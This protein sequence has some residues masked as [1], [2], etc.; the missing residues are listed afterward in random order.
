M[1]SQ[2][3]SRSMFIPSAT[4]LGQT[5]RWLACTLAALGSFNGIAALAE[6]AAKP[7]PTAAAPAKDLMD[8]DLDALANVTV[9]S[10]SK[11]AEKATDAPAAIF[12]ITQDDIHRSGA[13]RL[14]EALR[15][16]PG[17][18]VAQVTSPFYAVSARGF[19]SQYANKL[20]V[21]VD[22]RTVYS[23]VFSGTYWDQIETMIDDVDRIE[24][25]RGPGATV[26]GANAVNGVINIMTKSAKETQG[27]VV[28]VGGG[29]DTYADAAARYG[30][31]IS[32]ST[33]SRVYA[34]Y[35]LYN[36]INL[37]S[38]VQ[39]YGYNGHDEWQVVRGGFR[40]DS[41]VD[42]EATLTFSGNTYGGDTHG[43][44]SVPNL[45]PQTP[46]AYTNVTR[47]DRNPIFGL[48]VLGKFERKLSD[49][50]EYSVQLYYD[51]AERANRGFSFAV[52]TFDAEGQYSFALGERNSLVTGIGYRLLDV[53][54]NNFQ[55]YAFNPSEANY[56]LFNA[57][58]Q[59][60]FDL[61]KDRLKL[62][63]GSK[64]EHNDIT[65][66]EVQPSARLAFKPTE[67][68]TLWGAVSRAVRTPAL[69]DIGYY[70]ETS[71]TPPTGGLPTLTRTWNTPDHLNSEQ[72]MAYE[73]GYRIQP[74]KKVLVDVATFYN[75]YDGLSGSSTTTLTD[76]SL[77][78]PHRVTTASGFNALKGETYGVEL[79]LTYQVL[80]KWRA[81]LNYTYTD[82]QLH[83]R[84]AIKVSETGEFSAPENQFSLRNSFDLPHDVQ[85]D[86]TLRYV[87][88]WNTGASLVPAYVTADA[89]IGWKATPHLELAVVGRNLFESRHI[90]SPVSIGYGPHEIPRSVFGKVTYSF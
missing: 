26:W 72:L 81:H 2:K 66:Y 19:N 40:I 60:E 31:K 35:S 88:T 75:V 86:G 38:P 24:V 54:F 34:T 70:S 73:V 10:V 21:L 52:Q 29:T 8:L 44:Y 55:Q 67:S 83:Q 71:A 37:A 32:E 16:A 90:E 6:D 79:A 62:T 46:A 28:S 41:E 78:V 30:S 11:K 14:T 9:T 87:D 80:E 27:G 53:N 20:L 47:L 57:F 43:Y 18:D 74:T 17:L 7:A 69:T 36:D 61:V 4:Q 58:L 85:L 23:P 68:Q 5:S 50:S 42:K 25:I 59:D 45:N 63:L 56:Q 22:G 84:T 49:T 64:V 76:P 89:R 3:N 77:P 51:R 39:G 12:V 33:Y 65:G 1:K 82:L 13:Q 15:L 48:D